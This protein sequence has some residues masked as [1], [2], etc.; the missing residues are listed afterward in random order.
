MPLRLG[1]A[2][3]LRKWVAGKELTDRVFTVPIGLLAIL[4]RDIAAA[5]IPK[6]DAEGRVVHVHALR[7]SFGTHLSMAGVAPRTA[8]A[9]R[10]DTATLT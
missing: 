5:G 9:A 4:D 6:V 8:Q 2:A 10:C 3:D 1:L 7:H